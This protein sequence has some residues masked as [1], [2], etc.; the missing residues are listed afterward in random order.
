MRAFFFTI[1][2]LFASL[3]YGSVIEWDHS[4]DYSKERDVFLHA[5]SNV[6][7]GLGAEA[8]HVPDIQAFLEEAID[9][10]VDLVQSDKNIHWVTAKEGART[11]G[12]IIFETH[13]YPDEVYIRQTSVEP[14]FQRRG[15][16]SNLVFSLFERFPETKKVVVITRKVNVPSIEFYHALGFT[17][18]PYMHEGYDPERYFGM[19][20][21]R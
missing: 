21:T 11:V 20:L 12:M 4:I 17:D 14:D 8:L 16:G 5:F 19:E 2:S 9:E 13:H 10:E 15:I 3:S 18:C 6:Y 7:D 1:I